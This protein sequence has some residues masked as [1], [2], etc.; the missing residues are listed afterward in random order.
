MLPV[1]SLIVGV[2]RPVRCVSLVLCG[3]DVDFQG[4]FWV[5]RLLGVAT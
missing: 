2:V 3:A 4:V 1:V 5:H